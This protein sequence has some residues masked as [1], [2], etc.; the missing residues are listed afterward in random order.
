MDFARRAIRRIWALER[1]Q[2]IAS[3]S[4]LLAPRFDDEATEG[5]VCLVRAL[6]AHSAAVARGASELLFSAGDEL[7]PDLQAKVLA[8]V[9]AL[10]QEPNG[11]SLPITIRFGAE[12]AP[13]APHPWQAVDAGIAPHKS[14]L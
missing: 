3:V 9:E 6:R 8:A 13:F 10:R 7:H 1:E 14:S 4:L 2:R 5:R 11:T 12:G